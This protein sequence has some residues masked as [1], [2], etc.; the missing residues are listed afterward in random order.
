L[1]HAYH[2]ASTRDFE[3]GAILD[4]TSIVIL[5]KPKI[6]DV[7]GEIHSDKLENMI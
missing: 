2:H 7:L 3:T 6:V 4:D 5:K 1:W